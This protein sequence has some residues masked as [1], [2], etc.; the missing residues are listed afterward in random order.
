[1]KGNLI[2]I[3]SPSGGGKG[4]LIK[5]ILKIVPEIGYSVSFTTREIREGE[6]DGIDYFFVS[7][8]L[9]KKLIDAGE[10]LE[11]AEV[12][13]NFYGTSL[14]QVKSEIDLG[15][16]IILEID[17]QGAKSVRE[18]MPEALSI[19]I[20]P[21]S[22]RVLSERLINRATEKQEELELRLR[23]SFEEV[24]RFN[25]F[26]YVVVN[27]EIEKAVSDL[28]T[29]ILAERHKCIRQMR[30]IQGILDSFDTEN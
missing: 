11:Y 3:S 5:E 9:F 30:V 18:L 24:S 6:E 14:K 7:Q 17:V 22:Y 29:I 2:I 25:E 8:E 1:M 20:L 23:N 28:Q 10:F 16:D 13:G 4:T 19:F 26:E 21:P 12:H 15:H 27:G